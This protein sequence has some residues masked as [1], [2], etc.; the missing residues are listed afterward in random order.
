MSSL[1]Q[2]HNISKRYGVNL[3]FEGINLSIDEGD[4]I[5]LIAKNGTGKSTLLKILAGLETVDEGEISSK[6]SLRLGYLPQDIILN[7]E[8]TILDAVLNLDSP[9]TNAVRDYETAMKTGSP[10]ILQKAIDLMDSLNAWD[11]ELKM[12]QILSSLKIDQTKGKLGELSG[13]QQKRVALSAVL[14][15]DPDFLILD[16]P[17]NHLDLSMIEWLEQFLIQS[18]KTLLM[19]THDRYF[20]DRVC[21]VI[22]EIDDN[23]MYTYQGNY[24]Y[25]LEKRQERKENQLAVAEKAT[26]LLRSESEWMRRMPKARGTKAKFRIDNYYE[27][28]KQ[29]Q[30]RRETALQIAIPSKRLGNK[31]FDI[32]NLSKAYGDIKLIYDFSYKFAPFE[33]IGIVGDNG[34]GKST[35]LNILT[36]LVKQDSGRIEMGQTVNLSYYHQSGMNFNEDDRIIDAVTKI[37]ESVN[38]DK[39][40]VFSAQQ[41][42]QYFM[43]PIPKQQQRIADLSGGEKRRLYLC[44]VL[45]TRPNFLI[46][47]EPTNDLDIITL[48]VLEDYLEQFDG[49]VLIVSHDRFFMDKIVDH[50]FAFDGN[51]N[52][53]D[54]PG[55]YSV[56]RSKMDEIEQSRKN[57]VSGKNDDVLK[58][59]PKK[60]NVNYENRLSYKEKMEFEKLEIEIEALTE[61]KSEIEKQLNSGSL[62]ADE[63]HHK[64]IQFS[65]ISQNL[66]EKEFRWLELS[67]KKA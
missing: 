26:N 18:G 3:L 10:E 32:Y 57:S 63:L 8:K 48:Q 17:T 60:S 66:D 53:K 61:A 44:T 1:L 62:S 14:L 6:Q 12:K 39:D 23:A 45:M 30:V 40:K 54:F 38:L 52:V 64:Y 67:E 5:A 42:L 19:V 59:D 37:A 7:P 31:V 49:C 51:G 65:E 13:G 58:K 16:E 35:F 56:Y 21:N 55:N 36:G 28:K 2:T 24:S 43:F 41:F 29:A 15:E 25:Y 34:S 46:L 33:K 4:K 11:L 50:I 22:I 9:T 47:D 27:L 20:L